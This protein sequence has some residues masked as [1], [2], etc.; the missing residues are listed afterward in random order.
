MSIHLMS[1]LTSY[2]SK[3]GNPLTILA[4]YLPPRESIQLMAFINGSPCSSTATVTDHWLVT[5]MATISSGAAPD[6]FTTSLTP[7]VT[8]FHHSAGSCSTPPLGKKRDS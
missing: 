4:L 1:F 7:L 2:P 6:T 8:S 5:P 3:L